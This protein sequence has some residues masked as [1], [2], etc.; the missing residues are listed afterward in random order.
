MTIKYI[1]WGGLLLLLSVS[2]LFAGTLH[3]VEIRNYKFI[4]QEVVI[5][6]GDRVR[7]INRENRQYHSVWFER[8]DEEEPDYFFP[9]ESYERV[10]NQH[11]IFPYRC[12]PHP[13]MVGTINVR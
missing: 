6:A 4:P 12:G 11:G 13:E 5:K 8:L 1:T 9:E 3:E 2:N 7:W 10:F